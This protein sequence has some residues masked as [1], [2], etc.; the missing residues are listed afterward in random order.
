M[1]NKNFAF[2]KINFILIGCSMLVVV[3]GFLMMTGESTSSD[4]FNPEIFST[5][6][7]KVAPIVCLMGFLSIIGGILYRKK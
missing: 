3:I 1:D 6:R 7:I 5:M 4:M 2:G